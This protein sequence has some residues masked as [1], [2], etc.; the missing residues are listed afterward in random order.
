MRTPSW[1]VIVP[2][3]VVVWLTATLASGRPGP[4]AHATEGSWATTYFG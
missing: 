1:L 3:F 4:V 2:L